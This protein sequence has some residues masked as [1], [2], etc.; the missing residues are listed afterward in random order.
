MRDRDHIDFWGV[1]MRIQ[2]LQAI[3]ALNRLKEINKTI[4]E[5]NINALFLDKAQNTLSKCN[6][7]REIEK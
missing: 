1:N 6:L 3:V 2:P 7:T 5:R 4:S